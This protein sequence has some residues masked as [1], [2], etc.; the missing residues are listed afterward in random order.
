MREYNLAV[1]RGTIREGERALHLGK[2]SR[3]RRGVLSLLAG[4]TLLCLGLFLHYLPAS[5]A[6]A[7]PK[8][9]SALAGAKVGLVNRL[10]D[11]PEPVPHG[12]YPL[13]PA[14]EFQD[15]AD[16]GPVNA[17]L[18]TMLVLELASFR[19]SVGWLLMTNTRMH[20]PACCSVVDDRWWLA[21]VPEGPSFLGVFRL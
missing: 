1:M 8:V 3:M 2:K 5:P 11:A 6:S 19:A 16:N 15:A 20:Q 10:A 18:L 9:P 7:V 14:V 4:L 13:T 12:S 21:A 17:Y